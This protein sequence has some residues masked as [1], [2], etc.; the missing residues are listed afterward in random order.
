MF[1][2]ILAVVA[3]TDYVITVYCIVNLVAKPTVE[4]A[5]TQKDISEESVMRHINNDKE[6]NDYI[7][8]QNARIALLSFNIER[9]LSSIDS[10][11]EK[12][13]INSEGLV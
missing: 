11:L 7:E 12:K 3:L 9:I 10:I 2:V 5:E 4:T 6:F 1:I 8:E 13:Q